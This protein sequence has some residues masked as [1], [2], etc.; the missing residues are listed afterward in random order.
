MKTKIE[1]EFSVSDGNLKVLEMIPRLMNDKN[2]RYE[3]R[4]LVL[5]FLTNRELKKNEKEE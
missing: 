2:Y 1:N 4:K 5:D 3:L